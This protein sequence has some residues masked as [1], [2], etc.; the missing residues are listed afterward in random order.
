[1]TV[2]VSFYSLSGLA[3]ALM[4]R[5]LA[6]S[7]ISGS[8]FD[9]RR[10]A[11]LFLIILMMQVFVN[12]LIRR[13][14]EITSVDIENRLKKRILSNILYRD[15]K[16]ISD[17]HSGEWMNK[18]TSDVNVIASNAVR[19]MPNFC[20]VFVH[21]LTSVIVLSKL[22]PGLIVL[23]FFVLLAALIFESFFYRRIKR[24][25]KDVQEKDGF[26]RIFIQEC[27]NSLVVIK[28]YGKEDGSLKDL[29]EYL[30]G[31][32]EARL[33]R[34][35]F[36]VLMNFF[37]GAGINGALIVSSIWCAYEI[38]NH[39]ISYGTFIAVVQIISQIRSPIAGAYV[40]IPNFYQMIGSI[41]R[42]HEADTYPLDTIDADGDQNF[43]QINFDHVSFEYV[44][45]DDRRKVIEDLSFVIERSS[46]VGISGPSGCG[47]STLFKL[48]LCLYRPLK[49]EIR[50]DG[51]ELNSSS[52]KLFAY[53][54]QTN[55]LMKGSIKNAI[56]FS[57]TYDEEKMKRVLSLS[58]CDG[59]IVQLDQG[60]DTELKEKGSGLSEGQIQR[61]AIARALYSDRPVLLLD[62]VTS[63]LNEELELKILNNLREMTDKTILLITHRK[64]SLDHADQVIICEEIDG[65]YEWKIRKN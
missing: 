61:I 28:S 17:V 6:D 8:F 36:S 21:I 43:D 13:L 18:I 38:I 15:Y 4:F 64:K 60:L 53:V 46:F 2:L 42:V 19:L 10:Y 57:E 31:Y 3:Y 59:F 34:N 51:S 5:K 29:E 32:K 47:K 39:R 22:I 26:L 24:M 9:I 41:E 16:N 14:Q 20:S 63:A 37:F 12:A 1:M 52:R 48:L 7:A 62:E 23:L 35:L 30:D 56:C 45:N 49:G 27:I 50:V 55:M 65:D 58:C 44:D 11:L 40:S 54:P 33:K 25:H